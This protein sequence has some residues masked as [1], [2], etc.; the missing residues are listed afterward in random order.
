MGRGKR[1]DRWGLS[2]AC[3]LVLCAVTF[4]APAAA[5]REKLRPIGFSS[6]IVRLD[7]DRIGIAGGDYR[8]HILE[9]LREANLNAVGAEN[10]MFAKDEG[11]KA[12]L[13]L[14][15]TLRELECLEKGSTLSCRTAIEWHVLDVY[16][17]EVVYK[18]LTRHV[19]YGRDKGR[20]GVL[21][22]RLV[23]GA[24][25][26]LLER[27]RFA[28]LMTPDPNDPTHAPSYPPATFRACEARD[29]GMPEAS[30]EVTRAT[31]F[32]RSGRGFGSGFFLGPDGL[33]IT[34]AHAVGSE[35]L[36]LRQ[37]DGTTMKA[38]PIRVSKRHDVALLAVEGQA[39][40][41]PCLPIDSET[42]RA[43]QDIYAIGAPASQDLAFSVTR[44]I[45]SGLREINELSLLQTDASISPGNSG[46][47]LVDV[48]GRVVA[49][50]SRKFTG[51]AIEGVAFGVPIE[52]A[53]AGLNLAPGASTDASLQR[54]PANE[55]PSRNI[56]AAVWDTRDPV[57][58]LDP[59]GDE[60]R[61]R[62]EEERD[63]EARRKALTPAYV[64]AMRWGG[65]A[66]AIG[67]TMLAFTSTQEVAGDGSMTRSEYEDVRFKN[68]MS[69]VA[70][71]IGGGC[72]V[73]SWLL[74]PDPPRPGKAARNQAAL[75]LRGTKAELQGF[76]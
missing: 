4:L 30:D 58:S 29:L 45:V 42:K 23:V 66:M 59:E 34:A 2:L 16:R 52:V 28:Q 44:G 50:V 33:V 20:L 38:R 7:E 8:V 76:F 26:S 67:G 71:G 13:L 39:G 36:E 21:A 22:K 15:G 63:Y 75:V 60:R 32:L 48:Q 12:E 1:F 3:A 53:L 64:H 54:A 57:P 68:D 70:I 69:W 46:G 11:D 31:V 43:G 10:L 6:L 9:A 41:Y 37:R 73:A 47:P 19:E 24:L 40:T 27:P 72:F 5:A 74:V 56:P 65:L 55:P 18:V 17:D 35:A 25:Q 51:E 49:V 62:E 61:R 14:G